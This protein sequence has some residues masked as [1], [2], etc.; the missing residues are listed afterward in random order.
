[1]EDPDSSLGLTSQE[2][3]EKLH[4]K[5]WPSLWQEEDPFLVIESPSAMCTPPDKSCYKQSPWVGG[6]LGTGGGGGKRGLL[7]TKGKRL[8][9]GHQHA[10]TQEP[11]ARTG[12]TSQNLP[13]VWKL[14]G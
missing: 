11:R 10:H 1:M 4:L 9:W 2:L 12:R 6:A 8:R 13:N 5:G 7:V 3:E 14:W